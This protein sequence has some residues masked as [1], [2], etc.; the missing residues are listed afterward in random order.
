[1]KVENEFGQYC[2]LS[3]ASQLL[4]TRWTMLVIRELLL[5][6]SSFNEIARGMPLMSRTLLSKRLKQLEFAG[7]VTKDERARGKLAK[8]RPTPAC[9]ALGPILQNIA[10]WGQE[11]IAT[12]PSLEDVD[13]DVLMWDMRANVQARADFQTRFVVEFHFPDGPEGK[14]RHWL[15]FENDEVDICY[16]DPGYEI[17]VH[18]EV[19]TK[20]MVKIWM[21]WIDLTEARESGL[22]L[23]DGDSKYT[24]DI[25]SWLKLS[26]LS[27]VPKRPVNELVFQ[28]LARN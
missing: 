13:T 2:P 16:I 15:I 20:D 14:T 19:K 27:S 25:K 28:S 9:I 4:G 6:Y 23:V 11:W 8:Y 24:N 12:E 21:G 18:I 26:G 7:L 10:S 22:M 5:G 17:D 3:M 1:M